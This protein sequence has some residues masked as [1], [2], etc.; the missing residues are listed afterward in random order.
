MAVHGTSHGSND[1]SSQQPKERM[2]ALV[3]H[4]LFNSI[5]V[6]V[7]QWNDGLNAKCNEVLYILSS[8]QTMDDMIQSWEQ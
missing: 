4:V 6:M 3:F 8:N 1:F 7:W 5:S 2:G